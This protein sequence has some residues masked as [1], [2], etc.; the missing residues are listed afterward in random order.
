MLLN[1]VHCDRE[2]RG[3]EGLTSPSLTALAKMDMTGE[4][5]F[6]RTMASP[7]MARHSSM[8][9]GVECSSNRPCS[10]PCDTPKALHQ[11]C[12]LGTLIT[13][14]DELPIHP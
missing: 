12:I 6:W 5:L 7:R 9:C 13:K 2:I 11:G 1:R 4:S 8:G 14:K 3:F 10:L